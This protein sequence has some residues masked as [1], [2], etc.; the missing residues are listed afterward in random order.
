MVLAVVAVIASVVDALCDWLIVML[1]L[2]FL[3]L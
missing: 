1:E 3:I 2:M